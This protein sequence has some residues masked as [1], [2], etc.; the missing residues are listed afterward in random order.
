MPNGGRT[1]GE[2]ASLRHGMTEHVSSPAAELEGAARASAVGVR[3]MDTGH[4]PV[5]CNAHGHGGT[6]HRR[7]KSR[8]SRHRPTVDLVAPRRL[9]TALA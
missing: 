9:V 4:A 3:G 2:Q 8:R 7:S 5:E 1:V 6:S